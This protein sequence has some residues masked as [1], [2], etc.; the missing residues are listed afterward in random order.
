VN[1]SR[2]QDGED[3]STWQRSGLIVTPGFEI[4]DYPPQLSFVIGFVLEPFDEFSRIALDPALAFM[5]QSWV[6]PFDDVVNGEVEM[7]LPCI[8]EA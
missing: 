1:V 4:A 8:K 2:C 7:V 6:L 3:K 5:R